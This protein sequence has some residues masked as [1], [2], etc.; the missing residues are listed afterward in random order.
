MQC[1]PVKQKEVIARTACDIRTHRTH[2]LKLDLG[3][4]I[5]RF[6][7]AS[8]KGSSEC[9]KQLLGVAEVARRGSCDSRGR[10]D[11]SAGSDLCSFRCVTLHHLPGLD[12]ERVVER[13]A[14]R[15][16]VVVH[17]LVRSP[18]T[19]DEGGLSTITSARVEGRRE[20]GSIPQC[21]R[22][23]SSMPFSRVRTARSW[24]A[25]IPGSSRR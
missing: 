23:F 5:L 16:A 2:N 9:S 14:R 24:P 18:A 20:G 19:C 11:S 22:I 8:S 6:D 25:Q 12:H 3:I 17:A 4:E 10:G 1:S 13:R 15:L 21:L 7:G